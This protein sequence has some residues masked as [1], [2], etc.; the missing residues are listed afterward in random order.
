MDIKTVFTRKYSWLASYLTDK[1][2][3]YKGMKMMK[4]AQ[5]NSN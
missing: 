1:A 4:G 2:N 3:S 5:E